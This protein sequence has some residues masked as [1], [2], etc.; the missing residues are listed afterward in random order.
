MTMCEVRWLRKPASNS[1]SAM[2]LEHCLDDAVLIRFRERI[3][4]REAQEAVTDRFGDRTIPPL[5]P[6][7]RCIPIPYR[8]GRRG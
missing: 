3:E 1:H 8:R 7:A 6:F 4:E 5:P 2:E